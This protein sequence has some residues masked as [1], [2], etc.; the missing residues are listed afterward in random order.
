MGLNQFCTILASM[1]PKAEKARMRP[2]GLKRSV[3][4]LH[5]QKHVQCIFY[6]SGARFS[7]VRFPKTFRGRNLC[8]ISVSNDWC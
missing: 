3:D 2:M 5:E 7:K 6:G 1:V 4:R 8:S